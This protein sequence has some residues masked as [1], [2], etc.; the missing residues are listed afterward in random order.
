MC[1]LASSENQRRVLYQH[2]S[3]LAYLS[4]VENTQ[5]SYLESGKALASLPIL[6]IFESVIGDDV[7]LCASHTRE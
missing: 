3:S 4:K 6:D 7:L 5:A 2:A 1:F